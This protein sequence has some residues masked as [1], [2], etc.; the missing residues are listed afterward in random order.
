MDPSQRK[1][2]SATSK[3]YQMIIHLY[4]KCLKLFKVYL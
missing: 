3:N 2:I 1:V 4:G